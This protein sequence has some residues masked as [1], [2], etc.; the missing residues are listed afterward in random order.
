MESNLGDDIICG[1][2]GDDIVDGG[3]DLDFF[4]GELGND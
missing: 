1:G 4:L 2:K 3:F